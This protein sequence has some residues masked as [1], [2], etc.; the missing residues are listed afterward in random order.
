MVSE[1]KV[2]LSFSHYKSTGAIS[3]HGGHLDLLTVAIFT[4]FQSPF[5]TMLH[6]KF[7]EIWLRGFRG[8][9]SKVWMEGQKDGWMDRRTTDRE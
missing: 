8:G 1:K 4:N 5:N 9:R 2:F 3:R 7:E 6:I